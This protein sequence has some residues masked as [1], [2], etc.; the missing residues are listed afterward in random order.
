MRDLMTV[1]LSLTLAA[2]ALAAPVKNGFDLAG[3]LVPAGE[4]LPGGPQRDGILAV[5]RPRFLPA[6]ATREL[7]REEPVLGLR[8][9]GQA[10]AYPFAELAKTDGEV[11][12][13]LGSRP[14][15]VRFDAEHG[16]PRAEDAQGRPIPAVV[17]FWFARYAFHPDT[18]VYKAQAR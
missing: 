11:R 3:A 7:K 16:K 14:I 15:K 5:D 9:N 17:G 6:D 4:V 13:R 10:K 1:L 12:D 18:Q 8:L 2:S